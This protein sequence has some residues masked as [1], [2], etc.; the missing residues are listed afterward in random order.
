M[1]LGVQIIGVLFGLLMLYWTFLHLKRKEYDSKIYFFWVLMWLGFIFI[2]LFPY[3][4][5]AF[6]KP[7]STVRT[8]DLLVILGILFLIGIT[9]H[10]Y[11][12]VMKTQ[13]KVE[14]VVRK[15][16][17]ENDEHSKPGLHAHPHSGTGMKMQK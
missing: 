3:A 15:I 11:L 12:V 14:Q 5:D 10:N 4:L 1:V 9:F 7:L 8:L 16:A 2:S 6:T 13:K 17:I